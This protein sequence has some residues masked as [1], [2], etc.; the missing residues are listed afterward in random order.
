MENKVE[1]KN[2]IVC[3]TY[4]SR[5]DFLKEEGLYKKLKGSGLAPELIDSHDGYLEHEYV[6]GDSFLELLKMADGNYEELGR[7]F[8]LFFAWYEKYRELTKLTLGQVRFEKFLVIG[9]R[10]CN[11]DFGHTKPGYMEDDFARLIAQVFFKNN[12]DI[13]TKYDSIRFFVYTAA[14]CIE[15]NP[16]LLYDRVKKEIVIEAKNLGVPVHEEE[17]ELIATGLTSGG[18]VFGGGEKSLADISQRFNLLPQ[19]ILSVT[20]GRGMSGANLP[21]YERIVTNTKL[22]DTLPRLVDCQRNVKQT[23]TLCITSDMPKIPDSL[24]KGILSADKEDYAAVMVEANG[25]IREFPLLLNTSKTKLALE[26]GLAQN[27]K[28]S[29]KELL[30]KMNIRVVRVED[31]G[32]M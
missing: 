25:K 31:I 2:N 8:S 4:A 18:I 12:G 9:D 32:N 14:K 7:L 19:R 22:T 20:K 30:L 24:W 15:Y 5:I 21:D 29:L 16:D 10:L 13:Q 11:L 3:K 6:E 28:T 1:I 17:L 27:E 23:W 26:S